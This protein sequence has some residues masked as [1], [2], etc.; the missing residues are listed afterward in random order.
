MDIFLVV[1]GIFGVIASGVLSK[2]FIDK[3]AP[4]LRPEQYEIVPGT[5]I[6]PKWVSALNLSSWTLLVFGIIRLVY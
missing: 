5:G 1:S 3:R 2:R 6:I 4:W